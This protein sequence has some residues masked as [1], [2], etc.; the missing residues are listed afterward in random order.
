MG[1]TFAG[2]EER[3]F[4]GKILKEE[5]S[6]V[7]VSSCRGNV[8]EPIDSVTT[9]PAEKISKD[10]V[11]TRN[12][13]WWVATN[14]RLIERITHSAAPR[15][16]RALAGEFVR[17]ADFLGVLSIVSDVRDLFTGK[18]MKHNPFGEGINIPRLLGTISSACSGLLYGAR[19]FSERGIIPQAVANISFGSIA[20]F[21]IGLPQVENALD[22]LTGSFGL[23]ESGRKIY[24]EGKNLTVETVLKTTMST[25]MVAAAVLFLV[26][27][28][29]C[30]TL[31]LAAGSIGLTAALSKFLLE[32]YNKEWVMK[33]EN[34]DGKDE[35]KIINGHK[36]YKREHQKI[37]IVEQYEKVRSWV[38]TKLSSTEE[39][40]VK[41]V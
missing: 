23:I 10:T 19:I 28:P 8:I 12:T 6:M 5:E 36:V 13:F 32:Q 26:A 18:A 3:F 24:N 41:T 29:V 37:V 25:M 7:D 2:R 35:P 31:A 11:A 4:G 9:Y 40:K 38:Q 17:C 16:L 34:V 14:V 21:K 22:I 1:L 30:I 15:A 33:T 27:T 20:T 39:A